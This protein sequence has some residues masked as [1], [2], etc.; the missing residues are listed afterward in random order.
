MHNSPHIIEIIC[1]MSQLL[2][3]NN[4]IITAKAKMKHKIEERNETKV[5]KKCETHIF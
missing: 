3:Y 2:I 1:R 5:R 4:N